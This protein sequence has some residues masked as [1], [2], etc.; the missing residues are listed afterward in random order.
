M[1]YAYVRYVKSFR[2]TAAN[3]DLKVVA[4]KQLKGVLKREGRVQKQ[5]LKDRTDATSANKIL[6]LPVIEVD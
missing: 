3:R 5:N 6:N 1:K 4:K 2:L